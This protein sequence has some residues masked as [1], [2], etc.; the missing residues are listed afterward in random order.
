MNDEEKD[1][2]PIINKI[3]PYALMIIL[4]VWLIA[5]FAGWLGHS[6]HTEPDILPVYPN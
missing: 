4:V 5:S 3:L 2:Y 1:P 6:S